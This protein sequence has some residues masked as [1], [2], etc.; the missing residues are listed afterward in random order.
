MTYWETTVTLTDADYDYWCDCTCDGCEL[1]REKEKFDNINFR[2][3][4]RG[5]LANLNSS[6]FDLNFIK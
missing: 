4:R 3:L 2:I 5:F 1:I 6:D